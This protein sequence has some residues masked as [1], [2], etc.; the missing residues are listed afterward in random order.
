MAARRSTTAAHNADCISMFQ[1]GDRL[2]NGDPK[3]H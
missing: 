2:L 1:I 3:L